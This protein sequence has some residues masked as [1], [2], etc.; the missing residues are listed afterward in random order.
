[1]LNEKQSLK[2]F[3]KSDLADIHNKGFGELASK[4]ASKIIK[5]IR[6]KH[7]NGLIVE[8]GC[9]SGITAEILV[10]NKFNVY[11][12]DY[13]KSM[14]AL[15]K[16]RVPAAQF[17]VGSIYKENIPECI[18]VIAVGECLN[19]EFDSPMTYRKLK[20][21]FRKVYNSLLKNG[22]FIF[23][24]LIRD[25]SNKSNT[26]KTFFEG[27]N[28]TVLVEKTKDN[29]TQRLTRRIITFVKDGKRYDKSEEIHR[30]KL[31][32]PQILLKTLREIGFSTSIFKSYGKFNLRKNH[33]MISA[34]KK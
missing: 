23:D 34:V 7:Y 5:L 15:A 8:L 22:C 13:S 30:V 9:G 25:K 24:F 6:R 26:N 20:K 29:K 16:K 11:G 12:I 32:S 17:K 10:K 18:A 19:Y 27:R 1:M 33:F 14:I 21:L 31:Y 4:S 3:Y 28:W 2:N